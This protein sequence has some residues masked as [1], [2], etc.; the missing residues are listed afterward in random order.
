MANW[1]LF[2]MASK[3]EPVA[4]NLDA[5]KFILPGRAPDTVSLD[6]QLVL[7]SVAGIML[8]VQDYKIYPNA[9]TVPAAV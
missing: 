2:T 3:P 4:I 5:V 8:L 7:G 1:V 9:R 6:G